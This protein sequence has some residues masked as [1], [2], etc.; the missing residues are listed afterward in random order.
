MKDKFN[1]FYENSY[2]DVSDKSTPE[3]VVT[4]VKDITET[5]NENIDFV[6]NIYENKPKIYIGF[7]NKGDIGASV[8]IDE[9]EYYIAIHFAT[10][11]ILHRLFN[12]MLCDPLIMPEIGNISKEVAKPTYNPNTLHAQHVHLGIDAD[13]AFPVDQHR[14]DIATFLTALALQFICMHEIGHIANG[15]LLFKKSI[16]GQLKWLELTLSDVDERVI[17]PIHSQVLEWDADRFALL[18]SFAL[19]MRGHDNNTLFGERRVEVFKDLKSVIHLWYFAI[20]STFRLFGFKS[21]DIERLKE[22]SHP[23]SGLRSHMLSAAMYYIIHNHQGFKRFDELF[24]K[25]INDIIG[26]ASIDVELSF[27]KISLSK[28]AV[29]EGRDAMLFGMEQGEH[30]RLLLSTWNEVRAL[31]Q[32]YAMRS[33]PPEITSIG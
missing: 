4:I 17:S 16:N 11:Y 23:P 9:N 30:N 28:E 13:E 22:Y 10:F 12:R 18:Q 19:I 32:P 27:M 31:I 25:E 24:K 3:L 2:I 26:K 29:N 5:L 1:K 20:R 6:T 14:R 8:V 15:H 21:H 7:I 33:L